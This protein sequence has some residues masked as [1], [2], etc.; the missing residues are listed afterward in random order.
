MK[1]YEMRIYTIKAGQLGTYVKL[2]EEEGFPIIS[3]YQKLVGYWYTDIGELNEV[4]HIWEYDSL[5][6][7][8]EKR[9][10]LYEDPE[11]KKFTSKAF[12]LIL[13]Q[14]NKIMYPSNFSP[15]K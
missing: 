12:S 14:K 11:W 9:K 8:A 4:V 2:F 6:E 15:I 3:K 1:F 5:D 13:S 7:R 10:A